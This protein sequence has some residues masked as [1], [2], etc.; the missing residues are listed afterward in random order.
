MSW[1]RLR[2]FVLLNVLMLA[3]LAPASGVRAAE[4]GVPSAT[5]TVAAT[6]ADASAP[7]LDAGPPIMHEAAD[8]VART[9]EQ[10]F[11]AA[12]TPSTI[13]SAVSNPRLYREVF[14]FAYASSLH[15]PTIGYQ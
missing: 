3:S 4:S 9:P 6:P 5:H 7:T 2:H 10:K 1:H 8:Y 15:D 14:G 13:T 11:T 12:T